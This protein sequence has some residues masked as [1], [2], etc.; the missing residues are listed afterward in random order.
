[1]PG[2]GK[3]RKCGAIWPNLR[4]Q[5]DIQFE[6]RGPVGGCVVSAGKQLGDILIYMENYD[7]TIK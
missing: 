5:A 3:N 4:Q 1:M 6:I 7:N 2:G